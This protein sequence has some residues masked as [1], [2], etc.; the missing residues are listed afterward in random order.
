[1]APKAINLDAAA[2]AVI[3]ACRFQLQE[4]RSALLAKSPDYS[5]EARGELAKLES[6]HLELAK[7]QVALNRGQ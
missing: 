3:A 2:D 4:Q 5:I 6:D 7:R 1:M